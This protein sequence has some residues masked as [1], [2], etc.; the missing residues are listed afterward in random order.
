MNTCDSFR[1]WLCDRCN[2]SIGK[3]GDNLEGIVKAMNHLI[4]VRNRKN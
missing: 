4:L 3:L 2:A 1:G